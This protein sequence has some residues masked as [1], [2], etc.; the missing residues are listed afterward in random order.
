MST[1]DDLTRAYREAMP[2]QFAGAVNLMAHPLAGM[3]AAGAIGL[4]FAG[5]A[6][7]LWA[8]AIAGASQASQ[9]IFSSLAEGGPSNGGASAKQAP[10][11][12]VASRSTPAAAKTVPAA[13]GPVRAP[14]A[15]APVT[16]APAGIA[17]PDRPDDLKKIAGIGP[18]LEKTLNG[19]GIWTYGQVAALTGAE[20][21]W[22]DGKLGFAGRIGRDDRV[23]QA[24]RLAAGA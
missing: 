9:Q 19:L 16:K 6:F 10:L 4:G 1:I 20:I 21:A 17:R 2:E 23:G 24:G 12:L 15:K 7:G 22:L 13:G 14:A 5:H 11:R 3:A 8:G 18:K